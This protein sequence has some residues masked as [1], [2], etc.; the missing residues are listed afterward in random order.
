MSPDSKGYAKNHWAADIP[1]LLQRLFRPCLPTILMKF[2]VDR[3]CHYF[4]RFFSQED[5]S[6]RI[7]CPS[8]CVRREYFTLKS[9]NLVKF[10]HQRLVPT[11]FLALLEFLIARF[12]AVSRQI[13]GADAI[14]LKLEKTG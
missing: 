3:T 1:Q 5:I 9:G 4:E 2:K 10:V 6:Q 11:G 7:V 12:L 8:K 14:I 13:R